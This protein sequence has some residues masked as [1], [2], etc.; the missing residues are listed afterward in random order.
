MYKRQVTNCALLLGLSGPVVWPPNLSVD[1]PIRPQILLLV[2]VRLQ[3]VPSY[4]GCLDL[5]GL[6]LHSC[7]DSNFTVR[8]PAWRSQPEGLRRPPQRPQALGLRRWFFFMQRGDHVHFFS[9]SFLDDEPRRLM[10]QGPDVI[11]SYFRFCSHCCSSLFC[12]FLRMLHRYGGLLTRLRNSHV[13]RPRHSFLATVLNQRL[14]HSI[15]DAP[16]QKQMNLD[17]SGRTG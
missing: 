13:T 4:W 3:I 9:T 17:C 11:F 6:Q 2:Q 8:F 5:S 15:V 16:L 1:T 7:R 14:M 12:Y 10:P